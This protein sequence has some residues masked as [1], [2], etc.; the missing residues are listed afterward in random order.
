[1]KFSGYVDCTTRINL[2]YLW[3]DRSSPLNTG[4]F[5]FSVSVFVTKIIEQLIEG[6]S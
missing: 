2:E 3:D 4:F 5:L 1:M 6:Y